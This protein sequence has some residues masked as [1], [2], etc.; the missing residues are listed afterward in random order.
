M[1]QFV[2]S[3]LAGEHGAHHQFGAI[4]CSKQANRTLILLD[5]QRVAASTL[6]GLVD[7]NT[8]PQALVKR[9]D[10][11]TGGASA[12]Y[13]SDAVA[14]VVNFILDKDFT[15]LKG[16][17]Q[18][19]V[20]TYGDDRNY[21]LSLTAGTRFADGRGHLLLS[22]EIAHNDGIAG[23]GER[24]WYNYGKLFINPA[25]NATTNNTVP[26]LLALPN[27]GFATATPGGIITSGPLRGTYF[28]PGGTPTQ[29]N[30]G[31]IVSGNIMQG[32]DYRY[33]DFGT[34]GDLDPRTSR[35]SIFG[36][37]SYDV[38][39]HVQL[40]AQG[41]YSRATTQ[42]I[43]LKQFNLGNITIQPD[44]A[45]IP[46]SIA[47]RVTGTFTL[48]TFNE[49]IG[50]QIATTRRSSVR[51]IVGAQGDFD[52]I[53]TNWNWDVSAQRSVNRIYT[54]FRTTVTSR[55]NAA[56]DSVRV[57]GVIQ[58]R[59]LATNPGCVPY[60]V[61][62]TGVNSQAALGYV[63][64]TSWGRTT[65]TQNVFAANLRGEPFST[66]AGPVSI[67]TGVE[68][69]REGVTGSNDPLTTATARPYF[70]GNFFASTGHYNVTE[71]YLEAVDRAGA[72][73]REHPDR[74]AGALR[75]RR[76]EPGRRRFAPGAAGD[77]SAP[78]AHRQA[79]VPAPAHDGG[80]VPQRGG[81]TGATRD[82]G[83]GSP[84]GHQEVPRFRIGLHARLAPQGP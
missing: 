62:G 47:P 8:I 14:G 48:G 37:L 60:N 39:D 63:L 46:A 24:D 84:R 15:G 52:A 23:I 10:I 55:Y 56:I 6:S 28:G 59:T 22:G 34:S 53:G 67:A 65:L 5:G 38:S 44:N 29:F 61:F 20:T 71:G 42:E 35:Q 50:G 76:E 74:H 45:F 64:G 70:A 36:R 2:Q 25:Y 80:A 1:P 33:A 16:Q 78:R 13:G 77:Q 57:N 26:Q 7:I 58:C 79:A 81:R 11:V 82:A 75:H 83:G 72:G 19:G 32:G 49:D 66:W 69:R 9:V 12:G 40:F 51:A 31:P 43:A 17:V 21:N 54:D 41:S 30:Y 68:H 4:M 3:H 27:A 73:G 18:G